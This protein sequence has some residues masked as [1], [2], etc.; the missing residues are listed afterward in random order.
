[1]EAKQDNS[2][3]LLPL[4]KSPP[5]KFN[6]QVKSKYTPVENVFSN[7][8]V[9]RST[10]PFRRD[11]NKVKQQEKDQELINNFVSNQRIGADTQTINYIRNIGRDRSR[12]KSVEKTP[13]TSNNVNGEA[14][15]KTPVTPKKKIDLDDKE[16]MKLINESNVK[17]YTALCMANQIVKC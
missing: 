15:Q 9:Y 1:M 12:G 13:R 2:N 16:V 10:S 3:A 11:M 7:Q 4:N 14:R 5:P 6:K 17:N 8:R